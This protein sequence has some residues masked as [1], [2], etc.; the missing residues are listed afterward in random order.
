M[1]L[2]YDLP[3]GLEQQLLNTL[4]RGLSKIINSAHGITVPTFSH[5]DIHTPLYQ[6]N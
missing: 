3:V 1:V 4:T 6:L 2:C 5:G